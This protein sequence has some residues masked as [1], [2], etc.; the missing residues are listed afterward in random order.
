MRDD[1]ELYVNM[2]SQKAK[3]V[4]DAMQFWSALSGPLLELVVPLLGMPVTSA[5]MVRT[6]GLA[7]LLDDRNRGNT[8]PYLCR[9]AVARFVNGDVEGSF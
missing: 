3:Q 1:W 4:E 2:D 5:D 6:F 7:V 8:R 9:C